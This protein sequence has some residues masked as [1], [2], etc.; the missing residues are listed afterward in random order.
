MGQ[1]VTRVGWVGV[2]AA[3]LMSL[4]NYALRFLRW[5]LYLYLLDHRIPWL[6]SMRIYLAGFALT[7]T[8]GKAGEAVR[9]VLL[10]PWTVDYSHS[11]ALFFSERLSDLLAIVLL[12]LF[13]LLLYPDATWL[14]MLGLLLVTACFIVLG[15]RR[16]LLRSIDLVAVR[17]GAVWQMV[18]QV[19]QML[20]SAQRCHQPLP[21]MVATVLSLVA[22]SAE[23]LAFYWVLD[24]MGFTVPLSFACFVYALAMLAGALSFMPGGLGGAEAVM[25]G[26]LIWK[27]M[28]PA[29]A[30]AATVLIR[31]ATLWFAVAIGVICMQLESRL[32]SGKSQASG[33]L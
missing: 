1:A 23:A 7:T 24:W 18:F 6:D 27:G 13:G 19:L 10:R 21:L 16:L 25:A 8:P 15:Q 17:S 26:L 11:F 4:L 28:A 12:T 30:V 9:G 5:Q 14:I 3:L 2:L 32:G 29:D 22:W 33:P 20:A 31:L